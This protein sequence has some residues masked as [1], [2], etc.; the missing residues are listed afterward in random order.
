MQN[1]AQWVAVKFTAFTMAKNN[2]EMLQL[3]REAGA[4]G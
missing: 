1:P 3:R 4:K 2:E